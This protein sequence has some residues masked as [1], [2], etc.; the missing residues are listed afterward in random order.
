MSNKI[1]NRYQWTELAVTHLRYNSILCCGHKW[2]VQRWGGTWHTHLRWLI[3]IAANP[4]SRCGVVVMRFRGIQVIYCCLEH[5][6]KNPLNS[7]S[8]QPATASLHRSD[9]QGDPSAVFCSNLNQLHFSH[10][11]RTQSHPHPQ[12]YYAF[13]KF[14]AFIQ[15]MNFKKF[16]NERKTS[17]LNKE[18]DGRRFKAVGTWGVVWWVEQEVNETTQGWGAEDATEG[19]KLGWGNV[20][21]MNE[22]QVE[23]RFDQY[24]GAR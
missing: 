9:Y 18:H 16:V 1:E 7:L 17:V 22:C 12:N 19:G 13:H 21:E 8:S 6:L 24:R 14:L 3:S 15:Y 2:M 5:C 11:A 23:K 10:A 4:A 20:I